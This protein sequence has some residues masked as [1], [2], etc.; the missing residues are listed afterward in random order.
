MS[1]CFIGKLQGVVDKRTQEI[2]CVELKLR[3]MNESV[4]D[5]SVRVTVTYQ[6]YADSLKSIKNPAK[7]KVAI[8][9]K[10]IGGQVEKKAKSMK[11]GESS[12]DS[13]RIERSEDQ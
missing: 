1:T 11:E 5:S 12:G 6:S 8:G 3:E 13:R 2:E 7:T 10:S 4:R 9:E